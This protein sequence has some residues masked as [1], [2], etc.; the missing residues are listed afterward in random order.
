MEKEGRKP[1]GKQ[2]VENKR[3]KVGKEVKRN[4]QGEEDRG[5]G[6]ESGGDQNRAHRRKPKTNTGH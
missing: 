3:G 1:S 4:G 2:R 5:K 6:N